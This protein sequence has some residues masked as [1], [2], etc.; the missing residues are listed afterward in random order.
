MGWTMTPSGG[1]KPGEEGAH[2]R[3]DLLGVEEEVDRDDVSGMSARKTFSGSC[4]AI[5]F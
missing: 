3:L 2:D 1:G 5:C 4:Q